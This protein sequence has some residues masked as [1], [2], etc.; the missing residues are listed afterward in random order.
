MSEALAVETEADVVE[1]IL[2]EAGRF[3]AEVLAPLNAT[4]DRQ[5]CRW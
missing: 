4:G 5:G 2:T 1:A 3:A